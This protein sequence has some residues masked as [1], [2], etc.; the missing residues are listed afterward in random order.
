MLY[1]AALGHLKENCTRTCNDTYFI[2]QKIRLTKKKKTQ[3]LCKFKLD[4]MLLDLLRC[5]LGR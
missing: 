5:R 1:T 4:T 3:V 2:Y